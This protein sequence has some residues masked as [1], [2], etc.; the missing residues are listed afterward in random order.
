MRSS[1]RP[2]LGRAQLLA[3]TLVITVAAGS[4]AQ[5]NGAPVFDTSHLTEGTVHHRLVPMTGASVARSTGWS[6]S[7]TF[8]TAGGAPSVLQV[9]THQSSGGQ[10]T[11]SLVFDRA[12]LQ[13]IWEHLHGR[14]NMSI[15]FAGTHVT[16]WISRGDSAERA[17][18]LTTR[19]PPYSGAIDDVVTQ[20]VPLVQGYQIEL[21]FVAGEVIEADTIRVQHRERIATSHGSRD[22][23]VIALAEPAATE[24]MWVDA[25]TRA[26]LRH[27]YTLRRDGSQLEL[28]ASR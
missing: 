20:S 17:I 9:T 1:T 12:T 11:D 26:I 19:V 16:G 18:D 15:A 14:T 6:I 7:R 8:I 22:A 27:V 10:S 23:W 5:S 13:P 24:T 21:P 25:A 2:S 28:E 4:P 3:A